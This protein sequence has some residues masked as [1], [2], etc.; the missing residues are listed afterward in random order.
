MLVQGGR[1]T[2]E[3][4]V[5]KQRSS[6]A[7]GARDLE[8][9]LDVSERMPEEEPLIAAE[10]G[11]V[12]PQASGMVAHASTARARP[13]AMSTN[14]PLLLPPIHKNSLQGP[15]VWAELAR[16]AGSSWSLAW[17]ETSSSGTISP[18]YV[19]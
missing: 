19:R 4:E 3:A 17:L 5:P 7:P 12:Q 2:Q 13:I 11:A 18:R 6:R 9:S 1:R 10:G 15:S 8:G 16:R 14:A